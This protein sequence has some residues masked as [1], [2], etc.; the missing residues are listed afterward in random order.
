MRA[1]AGIVV[2]VLLATLLLQFAVPLPSFGSPSGVEPASADR[3]VICSEG[4]IHYIHPDGSPADNAPQGNS[5]GA[6]GDCC[7]LSCHM[8]GALLPA[9]LVVGPVPAWAAQL[10]DSEPT[11][12][13]NAAPRL[14][15]E[16]RGPPSLT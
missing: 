11:R 12:R 15:F 5:Q 13:P 1:R 6:G 7:T 3:V 16:A 8:H 10:V 9:P 4:G 2:R 14:S